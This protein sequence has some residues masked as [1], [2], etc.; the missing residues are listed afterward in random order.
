MMAVREGRGS[1]L[2]C[3]SLSF[4]GNSP[5]QRDVLERDIIGDPVVS[6]PAAKDFMVFEEVD[7]PNVFCR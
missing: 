5:Q 4:D 7:S 1:C 2:C 6:P 3:F